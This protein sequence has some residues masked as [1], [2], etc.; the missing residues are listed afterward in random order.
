MSEQAVKEAPAEAATEVP[1]ATTQ[2]EEGGPTNFK[3]AADR[4][5]SENKD[6]DNAPAEATAKEV[7]SLLK[8]S[9][10]DTKDVTT[11]P[12]K[13]QGAEGEEVADQENASP[14]VPEFGFDGEDKEAPVEDQGLDEAAFDKET[15]SQ[16]QGLD[17]KAGDA[18]RKLRSEL[19]QAK[20]EAQNVSSDIERISALEKQAAETEELRSRVEEL[21][22]NDYVLKVQN[23]QEYR[24]KVSVPVYE[25][26]RVVDQVSAAFEEISQDKIMAAIR[27]PDIVQ[28]ARMIESLSEDVDIPSM[29]TSELSR[30]SGIYHQVQSEHEK[31]LSNAETEWKVVQEKQEK[32][33]LRAAEEDRSMVNRHL[34]ENWD[35]MK[36]LLS[37]EEISVGK[38]SS[39]KLDIR[40][41]S[42]GNRAY[43]QMAGVALPRVLKENVTLKAEIGELRAKLG[44]EKATTPNLSEGKKT[45]EDVMDN[46]PKTFAEAMARMP[47]NLSL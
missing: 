17:P 33:A 7:Q 13:A 1:V 26:N 21:T 35:K 29:V 40:N 8:P 19:K 25:I 30:V 36:G 34:E 6:P 31:M 14:E 32:E 44:M 22:Q 4:F 9:K 28:R 5:F 12:E 20:L 11:E 47:D 45:E 27:E 16:V 3:E 15:D 2:V 10:S 37:D 41:E 18:W 43:S 39:T 24:D 46:T 38:R 42:P 23:S